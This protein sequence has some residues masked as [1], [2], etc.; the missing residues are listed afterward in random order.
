MHDQAQKAP[1]L[2]SFGTDASAVVIGAS[3]GIGGALTDALRSCPRFGTVHGLAR[4]LPDSQCKHGTELRLDLTDEASIAAAAARLAAEAAPLDLIIVATGILHD[5][6]T[7]KPEK[8]WRALDG[9][10]M[11]QAFQIN[12]IGPALIAKHMLPLLAEDRKAAFAVLSARVGSIG[13]NQLGG[14]HSYRAS[15]AALNMII[16]TLSIE[17]TRR[18]PSALCVGLHPGTVD[19]ALSE[20]FQGGVPAGTL[21]TPATAAGNLLTVLDRLNPADTGK[22]FAW[23]GG[24]IAP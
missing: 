3:G 24:P 7:L 21:V 6:D 19:T 2:T 10:T 22:V 4:S 5:G 14:W 9:A 15:K 20:P 17:L 13:D 12:T 1:L 11:A 18:N 23:D 16:R 8:S